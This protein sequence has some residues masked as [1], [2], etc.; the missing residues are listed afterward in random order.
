M[1]G[2]MSLIQIKAMAK[3]TIGDVI[4]RMRTQIKAVRQDAF[5]TDRAI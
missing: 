2:M 5:L 3:T 4:S 1:M